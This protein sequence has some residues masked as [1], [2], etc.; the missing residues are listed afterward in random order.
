MAT[1]QTKL[2]KQRVRRLEIALAS[3][4]ADGP[5]DPNADFAITRKK[6]GVRLTLQG[7]LHLTSKP[8]IDFN[9][10]KSKH[11]LDFAF[12]FDSTTI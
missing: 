4:T 10:I 8:Y 12:G 11:L 7:S 6:G 5:D 2:L 9:F 3:H 1:N